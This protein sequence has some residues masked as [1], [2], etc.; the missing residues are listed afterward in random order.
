MGRLIK[1][2]ILELKDHVKPGL[3]RI[4]QLSSSEHLKKVL[5]LPPFVTIVHD[6]DGR[7]CALCIPGDHALD[8]SD[9]RRSVEILDWGDDE[10]PAH[11]HTVGLGFR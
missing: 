4:K 10:D 3:G 2:S 1:M 7:R 11:R 9:K 8:E 5:A 6:P